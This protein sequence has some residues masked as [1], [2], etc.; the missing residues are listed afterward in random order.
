MRIIAVLSNIAWIAVGL[1][2]LLTGEMNLAISTWPALVIGIAAMASLMTGRLNLKAVLVIAVAALAVGTATLPPGGYHTPLII[3]LSTIGMV[4]SLYVD[5]ASMTYLI[6][7]AVGL[8]VVV[9]IIEPDTTNGLITAATSAVAFAFMTY[10]VRWLVDRNSRETQRY[11]SLFRNSPVA[12]FEEDF[13]GVALLLN[14]IRERGVTDLEQY[15][16]EHP[17]AALRIAGLIEIRAA[18]DSAVRLLEAESADQLLG[19]LRNRDNDTLE[20]ITCQLLAVWNGDDHIVVEVPNAKTLKGARRHLALSWAAPLVNNKPDLAHVSVAAVDITE[21]RETRTALE[22][23]LRSKDELVATVSHELRT[24]LTTVVGL[25]D[26][27]ADSIESFDAAELRE[28]VALIASEGREVST[29][30]ED[31]LVAAQTENGHL[32]LRSEH[33][34]LVAIAQEVH[35]T[36]A[37]DVAL[38]VPS[39]PVWVAADPVRIRQ[40]LRNLTVNAKRYGGPETRICVAANAS[41]AVLEVRDTGTPL[42]FKEREAIFDRYYRTRQVPGLTAS[43]G[44]GLTVSRQLARSMEGDLIYA[45]DGEEAIFELSLP[46]SEAEIGGTRREAT[47]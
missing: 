37:D 45:H 9:M 35:H 19:Q 5:R 46:L 42:P 3:A 22:G 14:E 16:T 29:I 40:I 1:V 34:D 39:K 12:M 6:T 33:I 32:H 38:F 11:R 47:A 10:I 20:S 7:Y 44:L 30:V 26:E 18:N 17:D 21:S 15:L 24:P 13:T 28:F 4:L 23:L 36:L 2:A 27:L 25:A 43:V 41:A 31:L 8:M